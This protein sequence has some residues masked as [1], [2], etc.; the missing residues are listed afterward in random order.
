MHA[1]YELNAGLVTDYPRKAESLAPDH[2]ATHYL[3]RCPP[4]LVIVANKVYFQ[5]R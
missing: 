3:Y 1:R 5:I 4:H 2:C